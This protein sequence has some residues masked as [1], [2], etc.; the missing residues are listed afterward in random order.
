V[1]GLLLNSTR[2][3][4]LQTDEGG[5]WALDVGRQAQKLLGSRVT[6]EGVRSAFDRL[7]VDWIGIA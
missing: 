3:F 6:V 4:V 1:T 5:V 2:G 7:D